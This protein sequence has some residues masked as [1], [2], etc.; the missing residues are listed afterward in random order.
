MSGALDLTRMLKSS[1][2]KVRQF[3]RFS[4]GEE[5]TK[6]MSRLS[7]IL[8]DLGANFKVTQSKYQVVVGSAIF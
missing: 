7:E 3:T 1:R 5:P 2:E 8:H 4:T 6:I